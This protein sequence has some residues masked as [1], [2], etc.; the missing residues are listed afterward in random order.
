MSRAF[1]IERHRDFDHDPRLGQIALGE[2]AGRALAPATNDPGTVIEVLNALLRTL[3]EL[4]AQAS[5]SDEELPPVHVP[6]PSVDELIRAGFAPIIREGAGE[7]EVAI[8]AFKVLHALGKPCL[9]PSRPRRRLGT[10]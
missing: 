10:N 1:V 6:R 8:R 9:T 4:P 3:S 2:I 7:E 5:P